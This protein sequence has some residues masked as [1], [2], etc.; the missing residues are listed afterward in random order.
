VARLRNLVFALA[1][2]A[3]VPAFADPSCF[4]LCSV[5]CVKPISIPDRWDDSGVPGATGW[6]NNKVW[7][8]E[9]FSDTNGNGI[10]DPGEPFTDGSSAFSK[11]GHG[12]LDG[13]FSAE[14]YDPLTTGYLSSKDLGTQITMVGGSLTPVVAPYYPLAIPGGTYQSNWANCN[15]TVVTVGD[16][17]TTE[18]SNLIGPTAQALRNIID[19][20]PTAAWADGCACVTS[21]LGTDSPRLF[22][23]AAHDPR[24]ALSAGGQSV[25]VTKLIGFFLESADPSGRIT[26]RFAHIQRLGDNSCANGGDFI[27][28]CAVPALPI[29]W[30]ALKAG[31]R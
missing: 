8:R 12:P 22:V 27:V 15:P 24:I 30:G 1:L 29:T 28:D 31:Y 4:G 2:S 6:A 5:D 16:R 14:L 18:N 3:P 9:T 17:Q 19:S 10:Y 21:P 11:S 7:D 23:F 20:D 13:V 25:L 26:G